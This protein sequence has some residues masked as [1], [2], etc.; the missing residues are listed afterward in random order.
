MTS[1]CFQTS[2]WRQ[3]PCFQANRDARDLRAD[4][5]AHGGQ[6]RE[7]IN[8][9]YTTAFTK[10]PVSMKYRGIFDLVAENPECSTMP[11]KSAAKALRDA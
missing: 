3:K 4:H 5:S 9:V 6:A 11:A 1:T 8:V 7:R 10:K 2:P